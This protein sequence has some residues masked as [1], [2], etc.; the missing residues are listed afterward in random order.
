MLFLHGML[1]SR[2]QWTDNLPAL[3][4]HVQPVCL[5]LWGHGD[6]PT[7][8]DRAH[9]EM[10]AMLAQ[11]EQVRESLGTDRIL[12]CGHSFG[13][14]ITLHY[15]ARHGDR[16]RGLVFLNS[17]SALGPSSRFTD[18]PARTARLDA[19]LTEGRP[20]LRRMPFHP[21]HAL[22]LAP[23]I[24]QMLLREADRVD[25][26]AVERLNRITGPQLSALS[27]LH[28]V[29]CPTLLVNG[30][31]EKRFQPLRDLAL[32]EIGHCK[33]AD[34]QAGH[35]VNLEQAAEFDRAVADFVRSVIALEI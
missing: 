2:H 34:L 30:L 10:P 1:L 20:A 21:R 16:L 18:D 27:V 17:L 4:E 11:I 9:Y 13:A 23:E 26:L 7:P 33:V 24:R 15:A 8:E 19:L 12:L 31:F 25:P 14:G 3:A 32:T 29:Q 5:E 22:R 28:R 6:S 35:A